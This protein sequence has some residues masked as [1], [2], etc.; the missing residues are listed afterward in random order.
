MAETTIVAIVSAFLAAVPPT[1]IAIA[2]L[3]QT[4]RTDRTARR[5][6]ARTAVVAART[7]KILEKAKEIHESTNGNLSIVTEALRVANEKI[8]DLE[9]MVT[10]LVAQI[11]R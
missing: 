6:S 8:A 7:G 2:V 11:P 5:A 9:K 1:I 10:A 4:R 3:K